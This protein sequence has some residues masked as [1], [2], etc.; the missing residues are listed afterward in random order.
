M[1]RRDFIRYGAAAF[2]APKSGSG[3]LWGAEFNSSADEGHPALDPDKS[4]FDLS[5]VP[6]TAKWVWATPTGFETDT[7][8]YF[9]RVFTLGSL[10]KNEVPIRVSAYTQYILY[11]NGHKVGFGPPI[12]DPRRRYFDTHN[13]GPYLNEGANV[14][15]ACVYSLATATEDTK[16][17]RGRFVF[18]G[19]ID[20]PDK[21]VILDT[22]RGWKYL[23][24]KTW[25]QNAPRQSMQLHYVEIADFRK[26][27]EG[28]ETTDFD[29]SQWLQPLEIAE[30]TKFDFEHTFQRELGQIDESFLPATHIVRTGEVQ[31]QSQFQI[32]AVQVQSE[33]FLPIRT[34]RMTNLRS[35]TTSN[36]SA[37]IQTPEP[38][39]DAAIVFDMGEM[40]LGCPFFEVA[41]EG[42]TV[43]DVS[44]SEYLK[45]GR[46]LA[47][48]KITPKESTYLT[49]R[50]TL[51]DG[52]TTWQR[53]DYNGYR[54]IQL[55]IRNARNPMVIH[56][57]GTVLRRYSFN[58]EATFRSS[59][60]TL[61][62]IFEGSKSTHNVNSHWGYCGSAWREHAQW[63]DLPW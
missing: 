13:I 34:V 56:K 5:E 16:K 59:D 37:E 53:N 10:P 52:K 22:S 39:H 38:D 2:M 19:R 14:L 54:Y 23:I 60:S 35:I 40:V 36:P 4:E 6:W 61:D 55:T 29:D 27:P 51:R 50:I 28:W 15:A 12:S 42:G 49:D 18:Q 32:P 3:Q 48:R 21:A 25:Q 41:G 33:R 30:G 44:I 58:Q 7:Y 24:P 63:S 46:V 20:L 45:N 62:K 26:N 8:V 57:V 1:R 11:V 17:E 31:R 47:F 9:R 43:V